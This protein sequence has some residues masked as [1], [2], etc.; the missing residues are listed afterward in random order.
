MRRSTKPAI[1]KIMNFIYV[2][3][4]IPHIIPQVNKQKQPPARPGVVFVFLAAH[5]DFQKEMQS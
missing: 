3:S 5:L 1:A 2:P 4:T